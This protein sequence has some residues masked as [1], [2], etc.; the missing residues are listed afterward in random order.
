MKPISHTLV[1]TLRG[2]PDF[3]S[4]DEETLLR[5]AGESMNLFWREGS[6]IFAPGDR[7]DAL[8]VVMSGEVAIQ[9]ED[10][11]EIAH[12]SAGDFFGEM[13]LLLNAT[14]SKR[15]VALSDCE[16]LVL[17]KE[18][19]TSLLE[20]NPSLSEHFEEVLRSRERTGVA[21]K[22]ITS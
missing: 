21:E 16:I 1:K 12:Q 10:G 15:A 13:S 17:P 22:Q 2:I 20:E 6:T 18:A 4:L 9:G 11:L 14:H 5:I 19:F 8:F 3:E 7:G